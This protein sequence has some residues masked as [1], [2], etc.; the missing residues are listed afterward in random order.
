MPRAG[1]RIE[2]FEGGFGLSGLGLR[3]FWVYGNAGFISSAVCLGRW[4]VSHRTCS[5]LGWRCA[6]A[7][8]WTVRV[9]ESSFGVHKVP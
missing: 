4:R 1:C 3:G 8:L 2:S 6:A 7:A 5:R 9:P